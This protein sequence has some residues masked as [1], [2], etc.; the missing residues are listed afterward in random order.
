MLAENFEKFRKIRFEEVDSVDFCWEISPESSYSVNNAHY[1]SF[2]RN[3]YHFDP[4]LHNLE[5]NSCDLK[6][7]E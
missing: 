7:V 6:G 1:G 2:L 3:V 5:K 4:S